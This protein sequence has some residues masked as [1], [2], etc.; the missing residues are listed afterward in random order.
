MML[1]APS[2]IHLTTLVKTQD[3]I[4]VYIDRLAGMSHLQRCAWRHRLVQ[5]PCHAVTQPGFDG[6]CTPLYGGVDISFCA[7]FI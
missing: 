5:V 3:V 6:P 1:Q 2:M 4:T 7:L